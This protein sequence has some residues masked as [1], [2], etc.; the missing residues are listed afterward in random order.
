MTLETGLTTIGRNRPKKNQKTN[1]PKN[2]PERI[3][4]ASPPDPITRAAS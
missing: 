2:T 4:R 3:S 1:L